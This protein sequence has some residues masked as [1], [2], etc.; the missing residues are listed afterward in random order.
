MPLNSWC[1]EFFRGLRNG[2]TTCIGVTLSNLMKT[3]YFYFVVLIWF[4]LSHDLFYIILRKFWSLF[5]VIQ[6]FF[7]LL[8][9]RYIKLEETRKRS[10]S[11]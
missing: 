2:T 8:Y 5:S 3:F 7:S 4:T 10:T 9:R 6:K 11:I 1:S